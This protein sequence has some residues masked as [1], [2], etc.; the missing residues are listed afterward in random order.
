MKLSNKENIENGMM[1][2]RDESNGI[3][4]DGRIVKNWEIRLLRN[5]VMM[6]DWLKK[7]EQILNVNREIGFKIS[8]EGI[9]R[10]N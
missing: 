8:M 2:W 5:Q 7:R 4:D 10:E 9:T 6:R 3:K 1:E